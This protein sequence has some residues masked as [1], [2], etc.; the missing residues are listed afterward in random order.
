MVNRREGRISMV[1]IL[2]LFLGALGLVMVFSAASGMSV[3]KRVIPVSFIKQLAI[4][5]LAVTLF[6]ISSRV[7][8]EVWKKLSGNLIVLAII[9]LIFTYVFGA[10]INYARR[11]LYIGHVSFQPSIFAQ[12]ALIAFLAKKRDFRISVAAIAI[13]TGLIL[14]Q[15]DISTALVTAF[16]GAIMMFLNGTDTRK[17]AVL[18]LV[19]ILGGV[20][21]IASQGYAVQRIATYMNSESI[22]QTVKAISTGGW[23][24]LGLGSGMRKFFYIPLADSDFIFSIVGEELGF[25]GSLIILGLFLLYLISASRYSIRARDRYLVV[26][27]L[28]LISMIF[29]NAL[30]H[31]FVALGSI[32]VTGVPLPFISSGGTALVVNYIAGG[33]IVSIAKNGGDIRRGNR[34]TY[35]PGSLRS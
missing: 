3:Y 11:W 31:I 17:V 18:S 29:I 19:L 33:V 34:R 10:R 6:F 15:P 35:I 4:F 27:G 28:G 26:L 2:P 8:P 14:F 24:G 30:I 12:L 1:E 5:V 32:P 21:Y 13:T 20:V 22:S 9:L 16:L 23:K 7:K 25:S